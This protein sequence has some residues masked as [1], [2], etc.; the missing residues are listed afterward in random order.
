MAKSSIQRTM[1]SRVPSSSETSLFWWMSLSKKGV[2][3]RQWTVGPLVFSTI[4]TP[5]S[6]PSAEPGDWCP[7]A[8]CQRRTETA[9]ATAPRTALPLYAS[10]PPAT[11]PQHRCSRAAHHSQADTIGL[12]PTKFQDRRNQF[13]SHSFRW[14]EL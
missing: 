13:V 6:S 12:Y 14:K 2:V 7:T 11:P 3:G 10:K 4:Q 9:V 8:D 5:M 1:F